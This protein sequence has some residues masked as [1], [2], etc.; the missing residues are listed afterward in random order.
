MIILIILLLLNIC[1]PALAAGPGTDFGRYFQSSR[2]WVG[3]DGVYSV[4]LD[5]GRI[6][7]LF[8][9]TFVGKIEDNHRVGTK[10]IHNS[11]AIQNR[12]GN[13]FFRPRFFWNSAPGVEPSDF[14]NSPD[15]RGWLWPLHGVCGKRGLFQFFIQIEGTGDNSPFAF[16]SV[17]LWLARVPNP[18]SSPDDWKYIFRKV[19][20]SIFGENSSLFWGSAILAVDDMLY[21]YGIREETGIPGAPKKLLLARVPADSID[22]FSSWKF[23]SNSG[24][25]ND[26][27]KSASLADRMATEFSVS[28]HEG[29]L[30]YVLIV[31]DGFPSTRNILVRRAPRPEGPWS[32]PEA[33]FQASGNE[34]NSKIF[35]YAAKEHPE[36]AQN[37]KQLVISYTNNSMDFFDLAKDARLYFPM[38]TVIPE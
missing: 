28:S 3:A 2:G 7:W 11:V 15:R 10:M 25:V 35:W 12:N 14:V 19:P 20:W 5:E 36:L 18:G 16:R 17:G 24:W 31:S 33:V 9:D 8:G 13:R 6:L 27:R 21:V 23:Y 30:P 1:V 38:F 34:K 37:R 29:S 22:N 26:F 32:L 4:L